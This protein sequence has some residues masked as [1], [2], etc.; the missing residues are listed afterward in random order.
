M[1]NDLSFGAKLQTKFAQ[2][3][4]LSVGIDPHDALLESW[5]YTLDASGA[6]RFGRE[7]VAAA[8]D[9]ALLVKP[10]IAFY[11]RFGSAGYKALERILKDARQ[12][13]LLIIADVKRGDI[14]STFSAYA[15]SWLAPGSPLEADAMTAHAFHGFESLSGAFDYVKNH[16]KG[17]FV[18]AATSNPEAKKLQL[19]KTATGKTVASEIVAEA[20]SWNDS[21]LET[22]EIGSIGVVLG[23]TLNLADFEIDTAAK[24]SGRILP[25][26]A[27]GFGHQGASMSDSAEVF[28][29]L[30]SG[31]IPH[32]SRSVLAGG[33]EG[34]EARI[35]DQSAEVG[36]AL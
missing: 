8:K 35:K 4:R 18:L 33:L 21:N 13:E 27:P 3:K 2:G 28:G 23:A 36:A 24:D 32:V 16:Q 15:E 14:G 1:A 34:L 17:L 9:S 5:G 25:I 7:I 6:E 29:T 10:Q 26:L 22:E 31:L 20:S 30:K 19:A 12:A 11:E